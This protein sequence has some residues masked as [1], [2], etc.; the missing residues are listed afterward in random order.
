MTINLALEYIPRRMQ[1]LGH[2]AAYSLRMKQLVLK[3]LEVR[4]I[5]AEN[6]L[7]ILI[8]EPEEISI[9][10]D[11]GAFDYHLTNTNELQYEHSGIIKLTNHLDRI[12]YLRFIQVIPL[13]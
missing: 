6:E 5:N 7:Y 8:E 10:S 11:T 1:E 2:G 13:G 3:N 4:T 12:M 9:E